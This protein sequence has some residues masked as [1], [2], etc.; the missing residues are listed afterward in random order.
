MKYTAQSE[1]CGSMALWR[2]V[3]IKSWWF[4]PLIHWLAPR[5]V[6][7]PRRY[8][9]RVPRLVRACGNGMAGIGSVLTVWSLWTLVRYGVG[10]PNPAD[11]PLMF[12]QHG[13][14]RFCR[15]PME[16]GNVLQ[17]FG[18]SMAAGCPRLGIVGVV[19]T[20]LTQWWIVRIEEPFLAQRF[21][22]QYELYRRNVPRWGWRRH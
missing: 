2:R 9:L 7:L 17:L 3:L 13:P 22:D 8:K 6:P 21:G 12:V 18:R 20:G 16:Q 15:N 14:Y 1:D 5:L 19:F 10:T 11:P 4:L